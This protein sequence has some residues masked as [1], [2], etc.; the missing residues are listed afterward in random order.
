M[1]VVL[2]SD[3]E[4][5]GDG[6]DDGTCRDGDDGDFERDAEEDDG[7]DEDGEAEVGGEFI[8]APS[9]CCCFCC[10]R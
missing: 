2:C 9:V 3:S 7:D 10:C 8:T 6:W 1:L 5:D 4:S